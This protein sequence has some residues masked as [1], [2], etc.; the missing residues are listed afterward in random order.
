MA[1]GTPKLTVFITVTAQRELLSIWDYN[2]EHSTLRQ[3]DTWDAFLRRKIDALATGYDDGRP[4]E[5]FPELR[6]VTAC[7]ANSVV[8][9][10][11]VPNLSANC[12][13][14]PQSALIRIRELSPA[15]RSDR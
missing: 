9:R 8:H 7:H 15:S 3:A 10:R 11:A 6:H 1:R 13:H 12:H 14:P 4:V 5:K 2:A